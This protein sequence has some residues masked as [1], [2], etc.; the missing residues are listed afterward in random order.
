MKMGGRCKRTRQ[1]RHLTLY[2][3]GRVM[4]LEWTDSEKRGSGDVLGSGT[5][6]EATN[7]VDTLSIRIGIAHTLKGNTSKVLVCLNTSDF[8]MWSKAFGLK[9]VL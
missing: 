7:N 1:R 6:R 5:V 3:T 8:D 4:W 9:G 2:D